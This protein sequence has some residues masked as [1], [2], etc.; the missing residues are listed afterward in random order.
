V[1]RC[2]SRLRSR[3]GR[4]S[5]RRMTMHGKWSQ[6]GV[7]KK[8]WSCTYVEDL[9]APDAVCEMC[10]TQNIRYVHY[11]EHPDY[12]GSLGCGCVCAEKMEGDYV[13]PR[14][15]EAVLK[16]SGARRKRWL[17]RKWKV[18]ARG[19][20]YLNTDG[21]N[22]TVFP[23]NDGGLGRPGRR[24]GKRAIRALAAAVRNQRSRKAGRIRCHDFP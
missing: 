18:S 8:G 21:F 4:A 17:S 14:R 7:P 16:A 20:P 13:G 23:K 1:R 22:I 24:S 3:I 6:V 9:G 5:T 12:A 15:R 19:N 2:R 10:E 11:M